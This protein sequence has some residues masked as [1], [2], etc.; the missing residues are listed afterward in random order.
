MIKTTNSKRLEAPVDLLFRYF[1]N[2]NL[3]V[4]WILLFVILI[5]LPI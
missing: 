5:Y 2:W 4:F 1:F 3:F